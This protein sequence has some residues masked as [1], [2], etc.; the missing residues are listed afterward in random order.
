MSMSIG[1][2]CRDG[3]RAVNSG[4]RFAATAIPLNIIGPQALFS[5]CAKELHIPDTYSPWLTVGGAAAAHHPAAVQSKRDG[6]DPLFVVIKGREFL[7][8][9]EVIN[10]QLAKLVTPTAAHGQEVVVWSDCQPFTLRFG[11]L[12]VRAA[13]DVS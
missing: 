5:F 12:I 13:E 1:I 7:A 3:S 10:L 9:G 8:A 2:N 11:P 6:S 4:T